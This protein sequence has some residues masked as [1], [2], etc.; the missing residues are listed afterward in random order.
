M[1]NIK[2]LTD[3]KSLVLDHIAIAVSSLSKFQTVFE[4]LGLE[5]NHPI[6]LVETQKVQVSF[7][8][9]D[10]VAKIELLEPTETSSVIQK[11]LDKKGEGIHHL[12]FQVLDMS[13]EEKQKQLEAKGMKFIYEEPT[14]GAGGMKV[15]FIHPKSCNGLLIELIEKV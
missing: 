10:Q 3:Q 4:N 9:I 11:Y 13:L 14:I 1:V 6:E 5:F 8:Q 2:N 15:N 12:A 7:T